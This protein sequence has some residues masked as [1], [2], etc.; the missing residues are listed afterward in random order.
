MPVTLSALKKNRQ[1]KKRTAINQRIKRRAKAAL[2]KF[3]ENPIKDNLKTAYSALDT[4]AKK[5]VFHQNKAARLKS[6]L[7]KL[8]KPVSPSP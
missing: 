2:K 4:A 3:R 8:I 5:R 1:D 6:R 7:A